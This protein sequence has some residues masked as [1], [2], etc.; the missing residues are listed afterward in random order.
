MG[1]GS[2][3][4]PRVSGIPRVGAHYCRIDQ[5]REGSTSSH[6]CVSYLVQRTRHLCSDVDADPEPTRAPVL[7]SRRSRRLT[8][9]RVRGEFGA[10]T[11]LN[12]QRYKVTDGTRRVSRK[13]HRA[14]LLLNTSSTT[15]VPQGIWP[16]SPGHGVWTAQ[17]CPV[18]RRAVLTHVVR[19]FA[20]VYLWLRTQLQVRWGGREPRRQPPHRIIRPSGRRRRRPIRRPIRS[21]SCHSGPQAMALR[22]R[23]P[24]A[25]ARSEGVGGR[26]GCRSQLEAPTRPSTYV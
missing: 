20:P 13:S 19:I 22:G 4:G 11:T 18:S 10:R 14:K 25:V 24:P 15:P 3:Y 21:T 23:F 9:S 26:S 1:P 7:P 5:G 12:E 2:V 16:D 6:H 17:L 8:P